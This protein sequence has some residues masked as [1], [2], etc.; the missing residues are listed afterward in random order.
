MEE[1]KKT[2][3]AHIVP[4]SGTAATWELVNPVLLKGEMGVESDTGRFKFGDGT[5]PWHDLAYSGER[6]EIGNLEIGGRN[7]LLNSDTYKQSTD[8][9]FATYDISEWIEQNQEV[10]FT[11]WGELNDSADRVVPY[12][13]GSMLPLFDVAQGQILARAIKETGRGSI[14]FKW[15]RET[16]LFCYSTSAVGVNVTKAGNYAF[17][18][19]KADSRLDFV[20]KVQGL[21]TDLRYLGISDQPTY[22]NTG[23]HS[24]NFTIPRNEEFKNFLF[25]LDGTAIDTKIDIYGNLTPGD[26]TLSFDFDNNVQGAVEFSHI[27]ISRGY[28]DDSDWKASLEDQGILIPNNEIALYAMNA[29][30]TKNTTQKIIHRI[31]LEYGNVATDWSPAPE[32]KADKT[33]S[34]VE[35]SRGY[36][37]NGYGYYTLP[38]GMRFQW[39]KA[40][41]YQGVP[42]Q[43][44]YTPYGFSNCIYAGAVIMNTTESSQV[45]AV[46]T[47]VTSG[48]IKVNVG[49]SDGMGL[50]GTTEVRV[51]VVDVTE[52][53]E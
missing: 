50:T 3:K 15:K 23:R 2:F 40:S 6:G 30:G 29:D 7:L 31:K 14:T 52:P 24:I 9:N 34:N 49:R 45:Q 11:I 39:N 48:S 4:R 35:L 37:S 44:I 12:N 43:T 26:Y 38:N 20:W 1:P 46:I 19:V 28:N 21:T 47:K 36:F 5:T 10:T 42:I 8:Y 51:F 16:N 27:K 41:F 25:G 13:S 32:D 33:L 53:E 22:N 17:K 18:Q